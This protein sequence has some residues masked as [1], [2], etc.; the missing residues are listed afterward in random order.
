MNEIDK[1]AKIIW[2]YMHLNQTLEKS[3]C[4]LVLG[5]SDLSPAHRAC[6]L[7]FEGYAPVI[8]FSGKYGVGKNLEKSEAERY[9][10]VAYKRGVP[11]EVVFLED[12]STNTGENIIFSKKLIEKEN[13]AHNKMILVQKPYMERRM[14]ATF[15]K[16]W[17]EPEIYV[18]SPIIEYEEYINNNLYYDKDEIIN[19]MVG[20]FE[21]VKEYPKLGFQIPQEIPENALRAWEALLEL[22]FTKYKLKI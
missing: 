12:Q 18:T 15:K 3:D 10:E 19:R 4:I 2:D 22:G 6:D 21:R 9:A 16:I 20:D 5:S 17:D 7:F 8:I 14:Y 13:I 1:N 11:K